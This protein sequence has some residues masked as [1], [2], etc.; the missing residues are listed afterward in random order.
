MR[1]GPTSSPLCRSSRRSSRNGRI[2]LS[3]RD[4]VGR[5]LSAVVAPLH[6]RGKENGG[7]PCELMRVLRPRPRASA[8]ASGCVGA[9]SRC[10]PSSRRPGPC[11][12]RRA[13]GYAV[14]VRVTEDSVLD[15][16]SLHAQSGR[17]LSSARTCL[18][19]PRLRISI[20]PEFEQTLSELPPKAPPADLR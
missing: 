10:C 4:T 20:E 16:H 2:S 1:G 7:A 8:G 13:A 14:A 19:D 9:I 5:L 12:R 17:R 6:R 18:V 15:F 3:G 11:R